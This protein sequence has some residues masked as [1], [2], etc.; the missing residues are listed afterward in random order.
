[1]EKT[2]SKEKIKLMKELQKEHHESVIFFWGK[3]QRK[4]NNQ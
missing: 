4:M 2:M 1:M 3:M